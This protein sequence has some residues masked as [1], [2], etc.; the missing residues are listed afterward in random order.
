V[1]EEVSLN[2]LR[3]RQAKLWNDE[4]TL[5]REVA[6]KEH[7]VTKKLRII[8]NQRQLLAELLAAEKVNSL[9]VVAAE[10]EARALV[11][12]LATTTNES[13]D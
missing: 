6:G 9:E 12:T 7:E 4:V 1:R 11:E 5:K 13:G 3:I 8:D 10:N 2:F